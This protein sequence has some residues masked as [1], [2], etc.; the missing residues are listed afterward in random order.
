MHYLEVARRSN[1]LF[2]GDSTSEQ[3]RILAA[4]SLLLCAGR[5]GGLGTAPR[6]HPGGATA[7]GAGAGYGADLAAGGGG[8]GQGGGGRLPP[9]PNLPLAL[10]QVVDSHRAKLQA[11]PSPP[12]LS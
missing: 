9:Y 11:P 7:L 1:T 3:S 10:L 12:L 2:Q 4:R 5:A 8:G 6:G